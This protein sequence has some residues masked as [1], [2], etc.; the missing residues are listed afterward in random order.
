MLELGVLESDG[1]EEEEEYSNSLNDLQVEDL[2][3]EE[4]S[5]SPHHKIEVTSLSNH[6]KSIKPESNSIQFSWKSI[7]AM[8]N[9]DVPQ[10]SI[11]KQPIKKTSSQKITNAVIKGIAVG[12]LSRFSAAPR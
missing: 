9:K 8:S 12:R 7:P 10:L 6:S 2:E 1:E 11:P 5:K 3:G 4:L